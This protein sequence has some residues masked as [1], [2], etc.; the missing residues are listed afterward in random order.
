MYIKLYNESTF[1]ESH[2]KKPK[3]QKHVELQSVFFAAKDMKTYIYST[4]ALLIDDT[5]IYYNIHLSEKLSH[6]VKPLEPISGRVGWL[7]WSAPPNA[8][9]VVTRGN[10]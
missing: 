6:L 4:Q 3:N 5:D 2:I 9:V 7:K 1:K 8:S 10:N